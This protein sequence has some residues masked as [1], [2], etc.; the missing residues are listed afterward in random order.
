M[1]EKVISVLQEALPQIDFNSSNTMAEDGIWDSLSMVTAIAELSM[2]FSVKIPYEEITP[3]NFNS[4][5]A[6]VELIKRLQGS[7]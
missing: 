5:D 3:D 1:R 7:K 6:L 4:V 2:E